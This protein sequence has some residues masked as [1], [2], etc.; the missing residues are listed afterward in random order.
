[1]EI[2]PSN[3]EKQ[4]EQDLNKAEPISEDKQHHVNAK[5]G[6]ALLRKIDLHLMIPLWI[7][8]VFGFLDRINLGNVSVLGILQELQMTGTDM[9]D[10]LQIFF[11]P[12]IISDVPSN[13]LLKRFAPS[14]W[15]SMLTFFWVLHACVKGLS[16]THRVCLHA[17]SLWV[18]A[19]EG[20][21]QAV[22]ISCPCIINGMNSKNDSPSYGLPASWLVLLAVF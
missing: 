4:P 19:K 15:I 3:T 18:F 21:F 8:F 6:R 7:V 11:V 13:V 2:L 1:M 12:Y 14:T 17:V 22:H 5:R 16:T 20:S 9:A 10:A